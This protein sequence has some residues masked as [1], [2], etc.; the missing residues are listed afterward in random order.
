MTSTTA[1]MTAAR[2]AWGATL[3][4]FPA[5]VLRRC[6][7]TPASKAA[8]TV[9]RLLGARHVLQGLTT[10][11]G[12]VPATWAVVPDALHAATMAIL[13]LDSKRWRT[14]ACVDLAVASAFTAGGLR[15]ARTSV[16]PTP[17][18]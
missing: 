17:S 15:V 14:A 13:A 12:V 1:A 4:A 7:R 3:T 18:A 6:P 2:I 9:V 11:A 8:D 5:A 16:P 10:A